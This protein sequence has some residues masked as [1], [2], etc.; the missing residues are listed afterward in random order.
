[1]ARHSI[2]SDHLLF[3]KWPAVSAL[4]LILSISRP[5]AH[6][7]VN[8]SARVFSQAARPREALQGEL[9]RRPLK[10]PLRSAAVWLRFS[11]DGR[12][13]FIQDP[14]AIFLF[15]RYPLKLLGYIK[16]KRVIPPSFSPDPQSLR[17]VSHHLALPPYKIP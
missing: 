5:L 17:I 6:S 7:S 12:Y 1:M 4:V 14:A 9:S 8:A 3:F 16:A 11:P 15:S 2:T 13:L 10:P